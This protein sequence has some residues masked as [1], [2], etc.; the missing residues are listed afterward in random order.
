MQE[1][2]KILSQTIGPYE[3]QKKNNPTEPCTT[4]AKNF[5]RYE[6]FGVTMSQDNWE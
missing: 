6:H 5:S 2:R 3:K 1:I 4:L